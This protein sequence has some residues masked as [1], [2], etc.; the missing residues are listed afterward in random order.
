MLANGSTVITALSS[1]CS[2]LDVPATMPS[3]SRT[4]EI[5]QAVRDNRST[6]PAGI[7]YA[8]ALIGAIVYGS[9]AGSSTTRIFSAS[10]GLRRTA[11]GGELVTGEHPAGQHLVDG[12]IDP[13][14]VVRLDAVVL[15]PARSEPRPLA[16][17]ERR[18]PQRQLG[19]WEQV[20]G[21]SHPPR[22]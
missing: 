17:L 14:Q 6:N 9:K 16:L 4:G 19:G 1:C 2:R 18:D 11:L 8:R 3:T 21:A 12:G 5:H 7:V 15:L 22:S 10:A 20:Q 13:A